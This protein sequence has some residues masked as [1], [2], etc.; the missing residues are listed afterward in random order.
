MKVVSTKPF[1]TFLPAILLLAFTQTKAQYFAPKNCDANNYIKATVAGKPFTSVKILARNTSNTGKKEFIIIAVGDMGRIEFKLD[2]DLKPG[3]F[4][5]DNSDKKSTMMYAPK[6]GLPFVTSKCSDA[7][8]S[9]TISEFSASGMSG[10]FN[11]T[12]KYMLSKCEVA[13]TVAVTQG[14][15]KVQF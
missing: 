8:G 4:A 13:E 12:G 11:F 9:I 15:F 5:L 14:S 7:I 10:T 3:T 6:K 1:Q 2:K